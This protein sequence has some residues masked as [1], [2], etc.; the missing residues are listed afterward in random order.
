MLVT[1][2]AQPLPQGTVYREP[3]KEA[4]PEYFQKV[5]KRT[6]DVSHIVYFAHQRWPWTEF[7]TEL[8]K[9]THRSSIEKQL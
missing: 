5:E 9:M 3:I 4:F 8:V 1:P 7:V 6:R 2:A